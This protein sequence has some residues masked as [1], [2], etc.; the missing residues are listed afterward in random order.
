MTIGQRIQ[1]ARKANNLTQKELAAKLGL[2]TGSIQQYELDKRQPRIEQLQAIAAALGV[3]PTYLIGYDDKIVNPEQYTPEELAE[4]KA[5]AWEAYQQYTEETT[6]PH[7][8]QLNAAYDRL[9]SKGQRV[10]VERVE[11]LTKILDYQKTAPPADGD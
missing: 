8:A 2:A 3:T 1:K 6:D 7:K 4:I 11:E 5:G 10:A 9:N